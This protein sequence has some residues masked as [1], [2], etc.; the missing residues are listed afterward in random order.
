MK[1][2]K[3]TR[4]YLGSF[5]KSLQIFDAL[6][7]NVNTYNK[8]LDLE[9]RIPG[10]VSGSPQLSCQHWKRGTLWQRSFNS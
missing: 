7:E 5:A 10:L 4:K 2:E 8:L 6:K 1:V 3:N 9:R